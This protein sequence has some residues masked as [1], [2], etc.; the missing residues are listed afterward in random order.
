MPHDGCGCSIACSTGIVVIMTRIAD[1]IIARLGSRAQSAKRKLQDF[2]LS[3][4]GIY[5]R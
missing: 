5:S 4:K 3:D 2:G 1:C